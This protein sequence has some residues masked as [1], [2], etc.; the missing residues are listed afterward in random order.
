MKLVSF[1][2]I[3]LLLL[4]AG[5]VMWSHCLTQRCDDL[6]S[7]LEKPAD[8]PDSKA[9]LAAWDRF[10]LHASL[11]TPYDLIRNGDQAVRQYAAMLKTDG[12]DADIEAARLLYRAAL[13]QIKR[14]HTFSWELIL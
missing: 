10:S 3:T 14:I 2:L 5:T 11:V 7:V 13:L 1:A 8:R 9:L 6:L 12:A 4:S